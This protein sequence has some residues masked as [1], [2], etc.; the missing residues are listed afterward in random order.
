MPTFK[1]LDFFLLNPY[2]IYIDESIEITVIGTGAI[3]FIKKAL[4][5]S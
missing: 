1:N 3:K 2:E 4:Q 5:K